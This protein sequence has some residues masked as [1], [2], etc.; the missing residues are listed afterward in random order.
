[1]LSVKLKRSREYCCGLAKWWSDEISLVKSYWGCL[2][3]RAVYKKKKA[4]WSQHGLAVFLV[5]VFHF[6]IISWTAVRIMLIVPSGNIHHKGLF[7]I[8][9]KYLKVKA[10][11]SCHY[12]N[13]SNIAKEQLFSE[14]LL[15]RVPLRKENNN[16]CPIDLVNKTERC[17]GNGPFSIKNQK[18]CRMKMVLQILRMCG[19]LTWGALMWQMPSGSASPEEDSMVT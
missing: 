11:P 4:T 13:I 8:W 14:R 9:F 15:V 12:W 1:M 2:H 18:S 5:H 16:P 19:W 7:I 17:T 6:D 10:F 3:I